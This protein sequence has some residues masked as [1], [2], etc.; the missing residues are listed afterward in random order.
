MLTKESALDIAYKF[1][2]ELKKNGFNLQSA[3]IFGS[4]VNGNFDQY[5]DID[6]AIISDDFTGFG[7][8]D[9]KRINPVILKLSSSIEVH[10]FNTEDFN[11]D[12]PFVREILK[13]SI[14]IN[15]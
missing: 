5:S 15:N 2:D 10:P 6:I 8:E 1:V 7:F 9:R 12:N 11:L 14:K 4:F 3:Y 13:T